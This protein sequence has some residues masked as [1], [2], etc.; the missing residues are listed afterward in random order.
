MMGGER[1]AEW[2]GL[3][4]LQRYGAQLFDGLLLTL[5]LVAISSS[6]GMVLGVLLALGR[7][8]RWRLLQYGCRAYLYFSGA[9]RC[10][11]SCS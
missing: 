6:A 5:Q 2:L 9:L 7:T 4:L 11:R 3:E 8:S 10:W 1:F